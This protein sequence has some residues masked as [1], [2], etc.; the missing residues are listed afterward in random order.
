SPSATRSLHDALP[1]FQ[2]ITINVEVPGGVTVGLGSF[3]ASDLI[4][5]GGLILV[6]VILFLIPLLGIHR[7]L[8]EARRQELSWITPRY[9]NLRSEEH[10]SE[11]QSPDHL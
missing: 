7:R 3:R 10:T 9:T 11:L 2:L 1:I 4:I 5:L 8:Q 6:G